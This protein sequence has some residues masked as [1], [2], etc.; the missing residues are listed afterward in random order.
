VLRAPPPPP[1]E[2]EEEEEEVE[3]EEEE[4][5]ALVA[6]LELGPASEE[7]E[8]E[9]AAPSTRLEP[10]AAAPASGRAR[11]RAAAGAAAA[12]A[13][14]PA[15]PPRAGRSLRDDAAF[16]ADAGSDSSEDERAARNTVG[17]VPLQWYEGEAH[18]GYDLQGAKILK[19]HGGRGAAGDGLDALLAKADSSRAWRTLY[20]AAEDATYTLTGAEVAL[21]RRLR[22]G[23]L[24]HLQLDAYAPALDWADLDGVLGPPGASYRFPFSQAP[25]PKRRFLP[26]KWEA[27]RVVKLIRALRRGW[28]KPRAE[29]E[30]AAAAAAAPPPAYLLWD[31][32][33]EAL[34]GAGA[35]GK[36]GAGLSRIAPPQMALPG[37]DQSYNPSLEYLPSAAEEAALA[38][39]AEYTGR[40]VFVPRRYA[41]MRCVPAYPRAVRDA[42]DRCLDLYLC[43]RVARQRLNVD[44]A[45]LL[46]QLPKPRELRPFPSACAAAFRAPSAAPLRCAAIDP[47]G[48][49]LALGGA[50]GELRLWELATGRCGAALQL[51]AAPTSLAFCPQPGARLLAVAFGQTLA[52]LATGPLTHGASA[53]EAWGEGWPEHGG[54]G[55]GEAP[56]AA[57]WARGALGGAGG[58][59][60][61]L[62]AAASSLAWHRGGDYLASVAPAAGAAAVLIHQRSRGASQPL[63]KRNRGRVAA[64]AF[65]PSR[66]L[67]FVATQRHV[68]VYNLAKQ[69]LQKTLQAG[70]GP[71]SSLAVHPRGD[72][73]LV[74]SG[75][76]RIAWFDLDLGA[77][78]YKAFA[79]HG[80]GV[81]G[82]AF[83]ERY[84]LFASASDDGTAHVFHGRVYD[85]L[86]SNALIVPLKVLRG[87]EVRAHA[88]VAAIAWHPQQPWLVTAGAD[89]V[90]RLWCNL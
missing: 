77:R 17:N 76:K 44:P 40:A 22:A 24:P 27:K 61:S 25:E 7:E 37:H 50:D 12:A 43:P 42:F 23:E 56:P 73:V 39:Q 35:G 38:E 82:V 67:L 66:P 29:R 80:A 83:H 59:T 9:R 21:L 64:A 13:A 6:A 84:P 55:G 26:S 1:A 15:L 69:A 63:F 4:D 31:E 20:D 87:H 86:N 2:E 11:R 85:D 32:A 36:T 90:A 10:R 19:A 57:A 75:D 8:E 71:L 47:G 88:G 72:N 28:I 68:Y 53:E 51:G 46:P 30:A 62:R 49:W 81:T 52:L 74:G 18:V 14:A 41:S 60:L 79:S 70:S 45:S 34:E 65:H 89:G 58:C 54:A 5:A 3:E 48:A 78:P 16:L 33:G